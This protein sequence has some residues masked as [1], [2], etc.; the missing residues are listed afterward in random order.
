MDQG[1]LP[2]PAPLFPC[3]VGFA[4]HTPPCQIDPML[5]GSA[6]DRP[7]QSRTTEQRPGPCPP[8]TA[9][10][11]AATSGLATACPTG[12]SSPGR[13][14]FLLSTHYLSSSQAPN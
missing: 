4:E 2:W 10:H 9:L 7:G 12:R 13:S 1:M 14:T 3:A 11:N 5:S 8:V 6:P